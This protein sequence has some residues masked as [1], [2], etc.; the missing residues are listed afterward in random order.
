MPYRLEI[1]LKPELLD[2]EG[3]A[4]RRKAKDY[5][6][7]DAES[8]RTVHILT[9]DAD[10]T[11][12]QVERARKEIFT[13]PVTQVSSLEPLPL[14]FDWVVWVGLR[15][16]VRDNAGATA[17]EAMEDFFNKRFNPG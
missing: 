12:D 6:D 2:A 7:I 16:G 14:S 15:P 10:L 4:L 9:V 3:E 1:T 8:I 5:F 11:S 17:V 13:N